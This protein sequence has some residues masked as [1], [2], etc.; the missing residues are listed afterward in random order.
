MFEWPAVYERFQKLLGAKRARSRFVDEFLRPFPGARLLDAGCGTGSLLELLPRDVEYVGFDLNSRYIE[1]ARAK[2]NARGRFHCARVGGESVE[3]AGRFDFVV[4]KGL[5]HHL[6]DDDA[7]ALLDAGCRYLRPGG[8]FVSMDN[9][10]FPNQ[11]FVARTLIGMDRGACVRTPD[12][13]RSLAERHFRSVETWLLHDMVRF[14]Y[15]HF[16]MRAAV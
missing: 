13:Y 1:S 9:V 4:A 10:L 8:V 2:Y 11:R 14:P 3:D 16:I 15:D 12:A 6:T 7:H 5:L